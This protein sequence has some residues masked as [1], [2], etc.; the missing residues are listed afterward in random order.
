MKCQSRM[1]FYREIMPILI[2]LILHWQNAKDLWD[3]VTGPEAA[4]LILGWFW[5]LEQLPRT[6]R[7]GC[8]FLIPTVMNYS[9]QRLRITKSLCYSAGV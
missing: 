9:T 3:S 4:L 6:S 2:G 7:C 5:C 8:Q 1:V